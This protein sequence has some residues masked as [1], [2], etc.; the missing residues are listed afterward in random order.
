VVPAAQ[1]CR[2]SGKAELVAKGIIRKIVD[3]PEQTAAA[4]KRLD[5]VRDISQLG[6]LANSLLES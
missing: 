6:S 5:A 4:D 1:G 3:Q 2:K